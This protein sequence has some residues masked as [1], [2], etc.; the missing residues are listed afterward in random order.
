MQILENEVHN[1]GFVFKNYGLYEI[2]SG[3]YQ[4]CL[5]TFNIDLVLEPIR[6]KLIHDTRTQNGEAMLWTRS[7]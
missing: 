3:Q 2:C 6:R 4:F 1:S 5:L 7:I